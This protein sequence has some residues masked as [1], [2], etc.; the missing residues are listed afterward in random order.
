MRGRFFPT[1]YGHKLKPKEIS[2]GVAHVLK[3]YFYKAICSLRVC[4]NLVKNN[5]EIVAFVSF[6]ESRICNCNSDCPLITLKDELGDLPASH[7]IATLLVNKYV[8]ERSNSKVS[9]DIF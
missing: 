5:K 1:I 4:L 7:F 2:L 9:C 3:H 6:S 8:G